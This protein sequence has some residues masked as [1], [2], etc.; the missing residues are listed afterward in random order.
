MAI[1][2]KKERLKKELGLAGVYA[3]ATGTTL[4]AGFFLLPGLAAERAGAALPV[5][6][7]LAALPLIPAVFS[8]LELATAM[9][10]AGGVY[11]FLD[12]SLGP[13]VG[14]VGGFGIW[15]ALILKAAFALVG[16]GAYINLI[17]PSL[18]IIPVAILFALLFGAVNILGA[19]R[20]GTMQ[21]VL[22]SGLLLILLWFV[23]GIFRI[24][25]S[26]FSTFWG[27]GTQSIFS[28]AAMV[29]ISYVGITHV[30]SV[31]E[32]VKNPGRNLPL[33][34]FLSLGTAIFVY[35]VGT[36]V[37]VG[38]IPMA[39]LTGEFA[40]APAARAAE[41][42]AGN[43]GKFFMVLAALLAFS[44]V[45][46]AGILSAS[47]Y[48]LA[49]SRDGT[50]PG[51]FGKLN[52]R[53]IPVN[54]V[55]V[56]VGVML[57]VLIF[58]DA[59]KI[60]KL[61]SAFQLLLFAM[62]CLAVIVMRESHID[63]YDPGYKSPFYPWMQITGLVVPFLFIA[64]MGPMPV[65]FTGGLVVVSLGWYFHYAR[66]HTKRS[67]AILH[68]FE[69]L[70]RGRF[71]GLDPELRGILKEKGLRTEDPF[72][73]IVAR[74][75][76]I[77]EGENVDFAIVA[78]KASELL[79]ARVTGSV[80]KIFDGYLRGTRVG[81]TP[82]SHGAALPHLRMPGLHNSE[83][84]LVQ[85]RGGMNINFADELGRQR[86]PEQPVQAAFFFISPE[87]NPGQHLRILAQIA[88]RVDD[89]GFMEEWLS[90]ENDQQL[91]ETLLHNDRYLALAIAEQSKTERL[92]GKSVAE[93]KFPTGCLIA[94][95][96][97]ESS[98]FVPRASTVIENGDRL[99]I[100]GE[101]VSVLEVTKL[102]GD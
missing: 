102:Y 30:A 26:H 25:P 69:R 19:K 75:Q 62:I 94:L 32:E 71:E 82:V 88:E 40:Y 60:A 50:L 72:D 84:V 11:Y 98:T 29:Y 93:A 43:T 65:I 54:G 9:P 80:D 28:T 64:L 95:I 63:S 10:R 68:V 57:F 67:G 58:L 13:I 89:D 76:V 8:A 36:T 66:K 15:L 74:A 6:Y 33:G 5:A 31:S 81:M 27:S 1:L 55:L 70:G 79:A 46:N 20:A 38:I 47:R 34:V 77:D 3:L 21:L 56:S 12:R 97:R 14:T 91:K 51:F 86:D 52:R 24:E 78:R 18:P 16:M 39:E 23:T 85:A 100:I 41:L 101:P 42:L 48:P 61:A 44:S 96:R 49:M 53:N 92:I 99:T 59:V 7:L 87:D 17:V 90:A 35:V 45:S 73:E 37:M 4:S 22:V 83:I 2:E